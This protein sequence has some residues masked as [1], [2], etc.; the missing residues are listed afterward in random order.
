MAAGIEGDGRVIVADEG[1]CAL[2]KKRNGIFGNKIGQPLAA[3][4]AV[5][6]VESFHLQRMWS[7]QSWACVFSENIHLVR[8]CIQGI[9]IHNARCGATPQKIADHFIPLP[10]EARADPK[11]IPFLV[12]ENVEII[13]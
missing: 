5:A 9:G 12:Q 6:G 2:E 11:G 10:P 13:Q 4:A 1:S 7:K 8:Q 3:I